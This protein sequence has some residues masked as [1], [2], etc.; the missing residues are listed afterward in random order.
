MKLTQK[1]SDTKLRFLAR[2]GVYLLRNALTKSKVYFSAEII[3]FNKYS[4]GI[5]GTFEAF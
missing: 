4:E 3:E 1:F 5:G 2:N